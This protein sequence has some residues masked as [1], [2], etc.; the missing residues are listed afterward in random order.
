MAYSIESKNFVRTY[1]KEYLIEEQNS[2]NLRLDF[3]FM[4]TQDTI[5]RKSG[6]REAPTL[7]DQTAERKKRLKAIVKWVEYKLD[8]NIADAAVAM[9]QLHMTEWGYNKGILKT[10]VYEEV[11]NVLAKWKQ[12]RIRIFIAMASYNFVNMIFSQTTVG[13]I[14]GFIDG[15]INLMEMTPNGKLEKNFQLLSSSIDVS[16]ERILYITRLS[17]DA[18]HAKKCKIKCILVL[19]VD[20][21]PQVYEKREEGKHLKQ[22]KQYDEA[23]LRIASALNNPSDLNPRR[24][25]SSSITDVPLFAATEEIKKSGQ[26][27]ASQ[28][29]IL[30]NINAEDAASMEELKSI[31]SISSGIFVSDSKSYTSLIDVADLSH[32]PGVFSLEDISFV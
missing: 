2:K 29:S 4:R 25:G 6:K 22:K 13:D 18:Y 15:H 32:F 19:R 21:D 28:I 14:S 7:P 30:S 3:N 1:I 24:S 20:Y 12:M 31:E 16:E 23:K 11:P 8:N 10:P 27:L 9:F 17:H 5:D 26:T